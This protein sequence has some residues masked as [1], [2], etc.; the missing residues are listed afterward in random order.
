[1]ANVTSSAVGRSAELP[2]RNG[3]PLL[4]SK[5]SGTKIHPE[6]I[7]ALFDELP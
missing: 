6:A 4:P 7:N 3:I 1:M 5:K 2:T